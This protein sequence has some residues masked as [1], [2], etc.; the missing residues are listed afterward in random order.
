[1]SHSA[2]MTCTL[3]AAMT[4]GSAVLPSIP[5]SGPLAVSQAQADTGAARRTARRTARRVSNRHARY[6]PSLPANCIR[7]IVNGIAYH[8]C[9]T[10]YY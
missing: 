2:L 9:G 1:M 8:R 7:V 4:L 3:A 10:V 5:I 6:Y